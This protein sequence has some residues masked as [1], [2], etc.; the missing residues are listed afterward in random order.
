MRSPVK[1]RTS[2]KTRGHNFGTLRINCQN[3]RSLDEAVYALVREAA[4]DL[5]ETVGVPRNGVSTNEKYDRLY[6]LL[7]NG[8]GSVVFVLDE[9]DLLTGRRSSTFDCSF[10]GGVCGVSVC[11]G[12]T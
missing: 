12:Y 6:D 4:D 7:D 9:I 2:R 11:G 10:A 1:S 3:L 8:Y 5:G